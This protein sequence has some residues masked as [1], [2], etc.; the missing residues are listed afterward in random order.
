[1]AVNIIRNVALP[2]TATAGETGTI[3]EP[4]VSASA[5]EV[6]FTG[7]WYAAAS[8]DLGDFWTAISPYK[9]LTPVDGGFCCDQT[10]VSAPSHSIVIWL[11][12]YRYD[13]GTNT[14]RLAVRDSMGIKWWWDFR[15]TTLDPGWTCQWFDYNSAALSDNYLYVTSNI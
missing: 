1:M 7:N 14:L 12:Q 2:V 5:N 6:F 10:V 3:G 9:A 8:H 13:K 4:S 11:L 15:P